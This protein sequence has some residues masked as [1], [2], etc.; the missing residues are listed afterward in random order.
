M[1]NP[2]NHVPFFNSGAEILLPLQSLHKSQI[3]SSRFCNWRSSRVRGQKWRLS[4]N[5]DKVSEDKQKTKPGPFTV[6]SSHISDSLRDQN[7]SNE[8]DLA[9]ICQQTE[10]R[11]PNPALSPATVTMDYMMM[12]ES[13][14]L[15]YS[16][17]TNSH[18]LKLTQTYILSINDP[19][20]FIRK[21]LFWQ[22][23]NTGR[24]TQYF[25]WF[26]FFYP[27]V[28]LHRW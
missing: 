3:L 22:T 21:L 26:W 12:E 17:S 5:T 16:D 15:R 11:F 9:D 25:S 7:T 23:P 13:W 20:S 6:R 28:W 18:L 24:R 4:Y 1:F 2:K 10:R 19:V 8:L 14:N 27:G